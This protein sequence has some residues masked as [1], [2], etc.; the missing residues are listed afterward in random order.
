MKRIKQLAAASLAA[1]LS[2]PGLGTGFGNMSVV[3]ADTCG[4]LLQEDVYTP[5]SYEVIKDPILHW[6]VR[7]AMNAIKSGVKLTAEKVGEESVQN[8]SYELCNHPEDFKEWKKPYYVQSLKGLQYAKSATMID[9]CYTANI[10]GKKID[11]VAPLAPLTQLEILY[12]KQDG[13]S[14]ISPLKDLVNLEQLDVSGNHKI[15]DI[16]AVKDMKKLKSLNVSTNGISD[17]SPVSGLTKLENLNAA[18]NQIK[19]LPDMSELTSLTALDLSDNQLEDVTQL[20]NLVNLEELNLSGNNALTDIRPLINLKNLK[21]KN[22]YLPTEQMKIDLFAVINVNKQFLTFNISKMTQDDI[23]NVKQALEA[24]ES[25]TQE[26]KSYVEEKRVQAAIK[27]LDLVQAGKEPDYYPEYDEGG[28]PVPVFDRITVQ[29][30]DKTGKPLAGVKF[31]R[32]DLEFDSEAELI[33][34]EDGKITSKHGLFDKEGVFAIY[35]SGD[36]YVSDPEKI[37]YSV[38]KE[39]NTDTVNGYPATG[40]EQLVFTLIRADEYV[41]RTAL[42]KALKQA[43]SI[44]LE[45]GYKYSED[46]WKQFKAAWDKAN[47]VKEQEDASQQSVTEAAEAL[48]TAYEGLKKTDILTKIKI[49]VKDENGNLFTRPF[50]IQVRDAVTHGD[51]WNGDSNGES[52]IAY[53][54]CSTEYPAGKTWEFLACYIEPYEFTSFKAVIAEKNGK[55]YFK[56]IDGQAVGPDFEKVITVTPK[57]KSSATRIP[58]N[59][60]LNSYIE[61]AK[62]LTENEYTPGTWSKFQTALSAAEA[63][64][65]KGGATQEDYNKAAAELLD[66]NKNLQKKADKTNL[67]IVINRVNLAYANIY[68]Q[69]SWNAYLDVRKV[70]ISVYNDSEATQSSVDQAA[71]QLEN[72]I[73]KLISKPDKEAL[74]EAIQTAEEFQEDDY[75]SGFDELKAALEE[76]KEVYVDTEATEDQINKCVEQIHTAIEGLE[77]KPDEIP[78][79]CEISLFRAIVQNEAG[80]RLEGIEFEVK[81]DGELLDTVQSNENGV[82]SYLLISADYNKEIT[83]TLKSEQGYTTENSHSFKTGVSQSFPQITEIDGKPYQNGIK[84]VF[85]LKE[86]GQSGEEE[87]V[88][89]ESKTFRAKVVD[90]NDKPVEGVKFASVPNFDD[91]APVE[92]LSNEKGIIEQRLRDGDYFLTFTVSLVP[93]QEAGQGKTWSCNEEHFF[94]T[95]NAITISKI[96]GKQLADAGEIV[97]HLTKDGTD[98]PS[99][100]KSK[101]EE[102]LNEAKKFDN[103]DGK[104]TEDSF[105]ALL[106]SIEEAEEVYNKEDAEQK[107]IDKQVEKLQATI[108]GLKESGTSQPGEDKEALE[109]WIS[110]AG[111]Y[112]EKDYTPESYAKLHEAVTKA[113]RVL[114]DSQ[115]TKEQIQ[116]ACDAIEE[117][118]QG[119]KPADNPVYCDSKTI[120]IKVVDQNGSRITENIPFI[121]N[122]NGSEYNAYLY[123]GVIEEWLSGAVSGVNTIQIYLK[124]GSV[125]LDGKQYVTDPEQFEFGLKSGVNGMEIDTVDGEPFDASRELI[126]TLKEK[127]AG[128]TVNKDALK[129]A[130]TEAEGL[131]AQKDSYTINSYN[132]FEAAL[133]KAKAALDADDIQQGEVD[134]AAAA[135]QSAMDNLKKV[136]GMRTLTIPVKME[137]GSPAPVNVEFVRRSDQYGMNYPICVDGEGNLTW[138]LESWDSGDYVIYLPDTSAYIET[139][140]E[141]MVHVGSDDGTPVIETI[142]GVPASEAS[143]QF[144]LSAKGTDTCDL[145]HFRA[146]V[147]DNHGNLLPGIKFNVENG[148]QGELTSDENGVIT[149]E[150]TSWD[151]DTTMKVVLQDGKGWTTDQSMEFSVITDPNDPVRGILGTINGQPFQGGE[152]LVFQLQKEG[153]VVLDWSVLESAMD[154]AGKLNPEIYTEE[155]YGKVREALNAAQKIHG[156]ETVSQEQINQMAASLE[157]AIRLLQEKPVE[158]EQPQYSVIQGAGQQVTP[159]QDAVFASGAD[160]S[161]FVKVLIDGVEVSGDYYV[162]T[163][164]STVVTLKKEYLATLTEGTHT[165]SIVSTDGTASTEFTVKKDQDVKPGDSDNIGNNDNKKLDQNRENTQVSPT[166][167]TSARTGDNSPVMLWVV[168]A[169]VA[170]CLVAGITIIRRKKR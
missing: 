117:A 167:N 15:A 123:N 45:E 48:H 81:A 68:T 129:A 10:E 51:A 107:E 44:K 21:E 99:V 32:K 135:L 137:D 66:A 30:V 96:D 102:K 93:D 101:L 57:S 18:K 62:L 104:Y 161:K 89:S 87:K 4:G 166:G 170:V 50:R 59:T 148:T 54:N 157:E 132:E 8:I 165:I 136:T 144:T 124:N 147:Q 108:E 112:L 31:I 41:D 150:V 25:L 40:L 143:V 67:L 5:E 42:Q 126:F 60:V 75:E 153:E 88:L 3:Q 149:Y 152:K 28:E 169:V 56:T 53:L 37:E 106:T 34:G 105:Q 109:D 7:S 154:K 69:G 76:A 164:G 127:P 33:T 49:I 1:V 151:T 115:A 12:L 155:T 9:I 142:N 77:E 24:Y 29:A 74:K 79:T 118:I 114:Q 82:I 27:N 162:V 94:E 128:V 121:T 65:G 63:A 131:I 52:G 133:E 116:E 95:S 103:S 85:N 111:S 19:N 64:A 134:A 16:A 113:E 156:D 122:M 84:L 168:W 97:F 163:E 61:K 35:P 22:T 158:P 141:I 13:L 139:P 58:D 80:T 6:A 17:L 36:T 78:E 145:T 2:L 120:R 20:S 43:G 46:S 72:A 125:E 38:D 140:G 159:D 138:K 70:A 130:V 98:T 71:K 146:V 119:L 55:K 73:E 23:E 100:D 86:E 90:E 160:Y 91:V 92:L 11:S 83:V 110:I 47:T 14:D 26:Q 39:G